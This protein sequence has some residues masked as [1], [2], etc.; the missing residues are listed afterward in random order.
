MVKKNDSADVCICRCGEVTRA[1][2][3]EAICDGAR[4]I[5]E[6]KRLTR[7]GM[8]LCQGR[9][10]ARTVAQL[11]HQE[12]GLPLEQIDLPRAR[13]PVRPVRADVLAKVEAPRE[14]KNWHKPRR[15]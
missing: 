11:I 3:I 15:T 10:C 1:E 7:A 2:V 5:D 12:T 4:S 14:S 9:T 13:P 6:V 8:G